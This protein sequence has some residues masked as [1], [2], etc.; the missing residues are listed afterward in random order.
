MPHE[1]GSELPVSTLHEEG[2]VP[3]SQEKHGHFY[4][5]L[6]VQAE[7][8][9]FYPTFTSPSRPSTTTHTTHCAR[10]VPSMR[11]LID[12]LS[13]EETAAGAAWPGDR[14]PNFH[15]SVHIPTLRCKIGPP[16][17]EFTR[18]AMAHGRSSR[19]G[20][21]YRRP[22]QAGVEGGGAMGAP[23]SGMDVSS[24][25]EPGKHITT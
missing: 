18:C 21:H 25:K 3:C 13:M 1:H 6:E 19:L 14:S 8:R 20:H 22:D 15:P 16:F 12:K 24:G 23:V 9:M 10:F 5:A 17:S 7:H 11:S 2:R 4:S